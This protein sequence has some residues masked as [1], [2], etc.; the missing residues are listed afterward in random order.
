M[1]LTN[2]FYN[3]IFLFFVICLNTAIAQKGIISGEIMDSQSNEK[4]PFASIALFEQDYSNTV[5]G[6]VSDE[7]GKFDLTKIPYGNYNLIISF[8]GYNS[9]TLSSILVNQQ[10][11]EVTLGVLPLV[12][13]VINLEGVEVRGLSNTVNVELDRRKY[14]ADDFE[15]AKGGT[16]VDLLNKL[17]SVSVGPDGNVSIRG[18]TEFMVYLNGKPTQLE[19]SVLLAQLSAD[20]IEN[21]EVITVPTEDMM[22]REKEE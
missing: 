19:P 13:S 20:A 8:M 5:K 1:K 16:A 18:T 21:I 15:T 3:L 12:Q 14:N 2:L 22:H 10:N 7:N 9:D 6:V 4:V 11:A 17:P